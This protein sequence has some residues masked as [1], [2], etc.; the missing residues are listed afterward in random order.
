MDLRPYLESTILSPTVTGSKIDALCKEAIENGFFGVCVPPFWVKRAKRELGNSHVKLVTVIGFP[1]GYQMT[2]AKM[3]EGRLAI[4]DGA[5]ELD[6]VMN[7]SAFKDGM[8]WPKIEFAKMATYLHQEEKLLKVIIECPLLD[9]EEIKSAALQC[10]DA[11]VDIVKT[12]TGTTGVAVDVETIAL[13][14][15]ILP[16]HV[17]IKAS[18]GIKTRELAIALVKAGADRL[19]T[20]GAL[21]LL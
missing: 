18:G 2:E 8:N 19:G 11:G 20:S 13:L 4:K 3:E 15:S 12:S 6:L 16:K 14:R 17:G 5:D 7:I 9:T 1:Y 21:Q 10:A